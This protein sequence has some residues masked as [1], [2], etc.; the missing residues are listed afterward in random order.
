MKIAHIL[1][2]MGGHKFIDST[3]EEPRFLGSPPRAAE[4]RDGHQTAI[5]STIEPVASQE[6]SKSQL[7][8][9]KS[10]RCLQHHQRHLEGHH[11]QR[12]S[13]LLSHQEEE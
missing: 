2:L 4:Q 10:L 11:R 7:L 1:R 12:R 6:E 9:T 8:G 3:Y 5:L 13:L